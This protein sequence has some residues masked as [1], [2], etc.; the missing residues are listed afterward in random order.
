MSHTTDCHGDSNMLEPTEVRRAVYRTHR[1][2]VEI[3]QR[4]LSVD[5]GVSDVTRRM[6]VHPS[7]PVFG[8]RAWLTAT[9][10]RRH[11]AAMSLKQVRGSLI[12]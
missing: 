12:C 3:P 6:L 2:S 5:W 11:S 7:L 1:E 8:A 10:M 4:S 9:D